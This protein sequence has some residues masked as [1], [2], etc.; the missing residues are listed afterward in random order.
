MIDKASLQKAK[1]LFKKCSPLFLALG[2]SQR[3]KI[4]LDIAE[5]GEV[6]VTAL[7]AKSNLS[8]PAVSHHLK[9]LKDYGVVDAIKKGTQIFYKLDI[10]PSLEHVT[11]LV[12]E[13]RAI[14]KVYN[15]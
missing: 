3:Q 8:R 10:L 11:A 1:D 14:A 13:I 2:D 12:S 7:S 6:N 5:E 9:I 4:L 15:I